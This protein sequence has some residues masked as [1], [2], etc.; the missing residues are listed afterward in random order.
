ML[1]LTQHSLRAI[2]ITSQRSIRSVLSWLNRAVKGYSRSI[3]RPHSKACSQTR[4][5]LDWL[6]MMKSKLNMLES[7]TGTWGAVVPFLSLKG[8]LMMR[9]SSRVLLRILVK[10]NVRVC[11]NL[12]NSTKT[13]LMHKDVRLVSLKM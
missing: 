13:T 5:L 10:T 11:L 2:A 7:R 12:Q 8:L 1:K 6:G 4:M 3:D 9:S